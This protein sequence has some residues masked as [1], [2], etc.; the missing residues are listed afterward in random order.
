MN[1]EK[2]LELLNTL[3]KSASLSYEEATQGY[4]LSLALCE[5][6][7]AI[8]F[9]EQYETLIDEYF[10]EIALNIDKLKY[11][12][13]FIENSKIWTEVLFS[14]TK[15]ILIAIMLDKKDNVTQWNSLLNILN[16]DYITVEKVVA[17]D[18]KQMSFPKLLKHYFE[19]LERLESYK[20]FYDLSNIGSNT[21]EIELAKE[22]L[23]HIK[24]A[25]ADLKENV[26]QNIINLSTKK[27]LGDPTKEESKIS[28]KESDAEVTRIVQALDKSLE[29]GILSVHDYDYKILDIANDIVSTYPIVA[30][31]LQEKLHDNLGEMLDLQSKVCSTLFRV[32]MTL[33]MQYFDKIEVE[34]FKVWTIHD[35]LHIN[36]KSE[37]LNWLL[38]A[39]ESFEI[40]TNKYEAMYE[41]NKKM[42]IDFEKMYEVCLDIMPYEYVNFDFTANARYYTSKHKIYI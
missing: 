35:I 28:L 40:I 8:Y 30:Y 2:A 13:Q 22:I 41:L 7:Q 23:T 39:I 38:D 11:Y 20:R 4:Q 27:E 42:P 5:H 26:V 31:G 17:S 12:E 33:G 34:C 3:K 10:L 37:V 18:L 32:D 1:K 25:R 14:G 6:K 24:D 16:D 29:E 9:K 36:K 21:S 15:E 19:S